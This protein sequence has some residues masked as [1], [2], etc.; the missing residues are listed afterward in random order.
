MVRKLQCRRDCLYSMSEELGP[1]SIPRSN[2]TAS[3]FSFNR[4]CKDPR[5]FVNKT[6]PRR[7]AGG[8][9]DAHAQQAGVCDLKFS[10]RSRVL[11]IAQ[12]PCH[13][14][15]PRGWLFEESPTQTSAHTSASRSS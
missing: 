13:P 8:A 2:Y 1:H 11:A 3:Q 6:L 7:G 10:L 5:A 15:G 4:P 14:R 9:G 12:Q